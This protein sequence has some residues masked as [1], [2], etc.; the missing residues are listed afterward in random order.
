MPLASGPSRFVAAIFLIFALVAA[1]LGFDWSWNS[2]WRG[3]YQIYVGAGA[4]LA[5]RGRDPLFVFLVNRAAALF[6]REGYETFRHLAFA[7][8]A[9]T[10]AW[11]AATAPRQLI[12]PSIIA[13]VICIIAIL[14]VK[15]LVQIREG[16][17]FLIVIFA[18]RLIILGNGR[19]FIITTLLALAS[20][21]HIGLAVFLLIYLFIN[22]FPKAITKRKH[23]I[24]ALALFAF[25]A[26]LG[27]FLISAPST[28]VAITQEIGTGSDASIQNSYIKSIYW[29]AQGAA[30]FLLSSR[31]RSSASIMQGQSRLFILSIAVWILPL[32][33]GLCLTLSLAGS[34]IAILAS[35]A[36]RLLFTAME[37]SLVITL[38]RGG[39]GALTLGVCGFMILDRCRILLLALSV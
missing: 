12:R 38:W 19:S 35:A 4:W 18:S 22:L 2:D 29:L 7:P 26:I 1:Y 21:V 10:A 31:L 17:G 28:A 34:S 20:L 37:L 9:V 8:F 6:G 11:L 3:Y 33:Y 24:V 23:Y 14:P 39:I 30:V 36:I 32:L 13:I 5:D 15:S 16:L 25:G 27:A